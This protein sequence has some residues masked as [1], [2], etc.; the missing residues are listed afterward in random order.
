MTDRVA[1]APLALKQAA[2]PTVIRVA[3]S[4]TTSQVAF[5]FFKASAN[6]L[7]LRGVVRAQHGEDRL[8]VYHRL[9]MD[10]AYGKIRSNIIVPKRFSVPTSKTSPPPRS[11][12]STRLLP[13]F[14]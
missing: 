14:G 10:A 11:T 7:V 8:Q 13:L 12:S 5:T 4:P 1:P 2:W 9:H 3:G 6:W